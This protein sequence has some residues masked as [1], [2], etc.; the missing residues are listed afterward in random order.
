MYVQNDYVHIVC[1]FVEMLLYDINSIITY[2]DDDD[3]HDEGKRIG[4]STHD[5][6]L[7]S[8]SFSSL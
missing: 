8:D 7:K 1:V 5:S 4:R 6:Q 2:D 3:D